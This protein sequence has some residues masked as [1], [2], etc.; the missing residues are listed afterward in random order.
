MRVR[1][2]RR[3]LVVLAGGPLFYHFK[4]TPMI[5]QRI[6]PRTTLND[7]PKERALDELD[8]KRRFDR[9]PSPVSSLAHRQRS[10]DPPI[11]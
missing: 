6:R 8:F 9:E 2:W 11:F 1:P 4:P 3:A 10:D 7:F 5:L